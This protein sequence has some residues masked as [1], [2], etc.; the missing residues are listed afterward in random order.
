MLVSAQ[1]SDD[2]YSLIIKS[3]SAEGLR[4]VR[5]L[6]LMRVFR[7]VRLLHLFGDLRMLLIAIAE[8]SRSV[9]WCVML[10]GLMTFCISVYLT[11]IVTDHKIRNRDMPSEERDALESFFGTLDV[12]M[13]SLY[14]MISEGIHWHEV[15]EPLTEFCSPWLALVFVVYMGFTVFAMLN[16]VTGVFVDTAMQSAQEDRRKVLMAQMRD[17]F[18]RADQDGSGTMTMQEFQ[19][20]MGSSEMQAMLKAVDLDEDE[21][22]DLFNLLDMGEEGELEVDSFVHGVQ[23]LSGFAKAIELSAF[24]HEW[25]RWVKMWQ[26]HAMF[27]EEGMEALVLAQ[28]EVDAECGVERTSALSQLKDNDSQLPELASEPPR[29]PTDQ[30]IDFEGFEGEESGTECPV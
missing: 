26:L 22:V 13:L 10:L 21:A 25:K 17:F 9:C 1:V 30:D 28:G 20:Q 8:S 29:R 3:E 15:L 12:S 24:I 16:V 6:R 27:L 19:D 18:H 2:A 14:Q 23:R 5:I 4:M 11:Q 7:L